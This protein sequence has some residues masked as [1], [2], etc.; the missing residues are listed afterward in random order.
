MAPTEGRVA[1]PERRWGCRRGTPVC[2]GRTKMHHCWCCGHVISTV[3][4]GRWW[5]VVVLLKRWSQQ[6]SHG[7]T[8]R[9]DRFPGEMKFLNQEK[10]FNSLNIPK[11]AHHKDRLHRLPVP[12]RV[13]FKLCLLTYKALHGLAPS[14]IADLCRIES[15]IE[16]AVRFVFESNLRIESAVTQPNML[17]LPCANCVHCAFLPCTFLL[18][19]TLIY[20]LSYLFCDLRCHLVLVR[21]LWNSELSTCL[22]LFQFSHKTRQIML[23]CAY[24]TPEIDF[25]RKFNHHQSFLYEWRL[26]A[27][28]IRKFRIGPSIRIESRIGRTIRNRITKLCI[29]KYS[30]QSSIEN[31]Q[32]QDGNAQLI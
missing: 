18:H 15:R 26:T 32:E 9:L 31:E 27:R 17:S 16:S 8:L 3:V 4:D 30:V 24:F 28:T 23:L 1:R 13:Q 19:L 6:G 2:V 12:Q 21:F 25:K 5:A 10:F 29:N 22:C 14:Y 20:Y 7:G 11:Q